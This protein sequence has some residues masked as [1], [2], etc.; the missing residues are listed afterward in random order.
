MMVK[1]VQL[2]LEPQMAWNGKL[3]IDLYDEQVRWLFCYGV[4]TN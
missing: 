4:V 2:E 1:L 3:E